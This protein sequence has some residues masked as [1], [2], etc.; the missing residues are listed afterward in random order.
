[1]LLLLLYTKGAQDL[2]A[3]VADAELQHVRDHC[4]N[5]WRCAWNNRD[6]LRGDVLGWVFERLQQRWGA[7]ALVRL[8][9]DAPYVRQCLY[10]VMGQQLPA[11]LL[12]PQQPQQVAAAAAAGEGAES[13]SS[14]GL[15]PLLAM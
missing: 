13:N 1:M 8:G 9:V 3:F 7:A 5:L 15:S 10:G 11:T 6:S 4:N 12:Q 2:A 14:R